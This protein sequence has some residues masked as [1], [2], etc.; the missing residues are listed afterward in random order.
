MYLGKTTSEAAAVPEQGPDLVASLEKALGRQYRIERE[1]GRGGM[2]VVLLARDLALDRLV[3]V[4]VVHPELVVNRTIAARFLAEARLIARLRHPNIVAI[5]TAGEADGHLYY[6]MDYLPGETL[7]QRLQREPVLPASVAV[8]IAADI[9]AAVGAAARAGVVHRDLKP[10]NIL[11]EGSPSAPRALLTDFGIARLVDGSEGVTGP[12]AVMG[13]PTYMSPEQAMGEGLDGRSDLYALGV[14]AYEMLAGAPPFQGAPPV[15]V[16]KLM[17]DRPR[18]LGEVRPDL[19]DGVVAAIMRALEKDPDARWPD[20]EAMRRVLLG[21]PTPPAPAPRVRRRARRMGAVVALALAAFT[22]V[23]GLR[24]RS[25]PPPGVNPRLSML[26]LPFDNLRED[27]ALAWLRDGSVSM[28]T[29][30]LGQWS[31]L[32]VI[33]QDRVHDLLS[34][35]ELRDDD[36]IGLDQARRLARRAGAWTVV[37]GDFTGGG[38]GGGVGG[39]GGGGD[40][41]RLTARAYD[42]ATGRRLDV[43]E[44][45]GLASGD[46]RPLFDDLAARLLDLSGAP[47]EGR[48]SALASVTTESLEAY[49]AYL[50]GLEHLNHWELAPAEADFRRAV[51]L[52]TTFSLAYYRLAQTRGWVIGVADTVSR[53]AV[54]A[55]TRFSERLPDRE[56]RMIDAYRAMIEGDFARS[57]ALYTEWLERDSADADAWYGLGD[58]IFHDSVAGGT[59]DG[60]TRSLRA[61]RRAVTLDP[62]YVLAYEHITF[63]LTNATRANAAYALAARDSLVP[64]WAAGRPALDSAARQAAVQRARIHAVETARTWVG[65]QPGT[66]RAR[67]ALF[68]ALLASEEF[69]A[70]ST[71]V[72]ELRRLLPQEG[73]D[74]AAFL[75]ARVR[76]AS[77]DR[78]G[79]AALVRGTTRMLADRN[80]ALPDFG[81]E[82]VQDVAAGANMLAYQGDLDGAANVVALADEIRRAA[83][84]LSLEAPVWNQPKLWEWARLAQLY[85]S[86][87]GPE[88][89][90]R[91][92]WSSV[93]ETARR[94]PSAE[95]P[96]VAGAGAAAAAALLIAADPD[97]RPLAELG[98]LTGRPPP[99]S[100]KA[101][102]ALSRGDSAGARAALRDTTRPAQPKEDKDALYWGFASGD[103]RPLEA[104]ALFQLGD[105]QGAL[106]RLEGLDE[107]HLAQ[108]GFDARWGLLGRVHLL[109][110]L[111]NERLGR[112]RLAATEFRKVIDQ[113]SA[114]DE[115]L[116]VFVQ[117]AQAGLARLSGRA[118]GSY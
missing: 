16:S 70:A 102:L 111:A 116:Q 22:L 92:L 67:R 19:P 42:V 55:A 98:A 43:V 88:R 103:P 4:K 62:G 66:A 72:R 13:T 12:T 61:F 52:D 86:A 28:L 77:G 74:L 45:A 69:A 34:Q 41:L 73:R 91:R 93:A 35:A 2:G 21:E 46:V 83:P 59:A 54:L 112:P 107:G 80:V 48:G 18:P 31:D 17:V 82:L 53:N 85:A 99:R 57:Q 118:R 23:L 8:G 37:L 96:S 108:R 109:R 68:E 106:D 49:Q 1:I 7:R 29:L 63:L 79:A 20:G 75:E 38:V 15:V 64:A 47:T 101:L 113:W 115:A 78:A 105:Y 36:P 65:Q 90:L 87:G 44:A 110:G 76:F 40:S 6:V 10:E 3:A 25:S 84:P 50:S 5:H 81:R 60:M 33:E 39:G 51:D 71:E 100:I 11:L 117:Q 27:P 24:S 94:A 26:V 89:E 9:A 104:E 14:I 32:S 30:A 95:R 56:R 114:A 97:P 58:A